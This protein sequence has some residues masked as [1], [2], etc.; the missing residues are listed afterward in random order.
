MGILRKTANTVRGFFAFA[1]SFK[2]WGLIDYLKDPWKVHRGFTKEMVRLCEINRSNQ[3]EFISDREHNSRWPFNRPYHG[4]VSDKLALIRILHQYKECM[5]KYYFFIDKHGLLP[6]WDCPDDGSLSTRM[7]ADA[8]V[9]LLDREKILVIKPT[10]SEVGIGVMVAQKKGEIYSINNEEYTI[11][12]MK[13]CIGQAYN[14]IVTEYVIQH[15]YARKI[16]PTSLNTIRMLGVWNSETKQFDIIRSFHRFGCNGNVVDNVG[17]GNGVLVYVNTETGIL[18]RDGLINTKKEGDRR[19][20]H[21]IHPDNNIKLTG[22]VIPGYL[23][24]KEKVLKIM[25]ENSYLRYIGFDVAI[26][27]DGFRIIEANGSS[28][29]TAAQVRGGF[30]KDKRMRELFNL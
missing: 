6:L 26:T 23:D 24:M 8:F 29:P 28:T 2:E 16:C 25:N 14:N 1:E 17:S 11:A 7:D 4:A 18:E 3:K 21:I 13:E 20:D 10:H 12:E 19:V 27:D 5:P 22:L 30:L 9:K 15:D